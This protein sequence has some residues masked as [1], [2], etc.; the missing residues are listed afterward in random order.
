M[1][2][3]DVML[4]RAMTP[5][6]Q[7]ETYVSIANA[8]AAKAEKA[9]QDAEEAIATIE[10][11]ADE[12]A[13]AQ[14]SASDLLSTAQ[15][16]LETAQQA[17]LNIPDTEDIDAEV[18]KLVV[19]TNVI[20][21]QNAKTIQIVSTYPDNTLNTQNVTKLYKTTGT[22]EDGTMT[23]KAI[24]TYVEDVQSTLQNNINNITIVNNGSGEG[25]VSNLG[26]DNSGKLVIIGSDGNIIAGNVIESD[27]IEALILTGNY[28]AQEAVGLEVDYTN[29]YMKRVQQAANLSMGEDFDEY[30]MY[31]GRRRCV[32]DNDGLIIAFEGDNNFASAISGANGQVMV[33]Q[34]KFY[35]QRIPLATSLNT[36]GKIINKDSIMISTTSQNGFKL[37]P[38][39][40]NAAGEELDY[41]LFSAYEGGLYDVS[42]QTVP[43]NVASNVDF[44]HDLLTSVPNS[45]P[46]TGSSSLNLERAEQLA[47]NR[48]SGWH[49]MNMMAES[50]N[51]MLEIIEFGTMN[52]QVALGKG[53]CDISNSGNINYSA[54]TGSTSSLGNTSGSASSTTF[55]TN[56]SITTETTAGKVAISYRGMENPWGNTWNMLNGIFIVGNSYQ[57]GG[58]PK[59]CTNYSYNY[60]APSNDYQNAD[61]SLP[62]G[63]GWIATMGYG[64]KDLDWLLMPASCGNNANSSLP[65]GD[66][67]WFNNNLNGNRVVVSGGSWAFG[68]AN[69]PFYYGCDK[70]PSDTSYKSY[71]ARLMFIPEKNETYLANIAKA[72]G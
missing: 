63:E 12:I 42:A 25:G 31:G 13:I 40:R 8:A 26:A 24:K 61:F 17:Q 45:K 67:G 32:V 54:L 9:K 20:D 22:N 10:A 7:T 69:G 1:D 64:N 38:I 23:Q 18:K 60:S 57:D 68:E 19:N 15:E 28:T 5:Q 33:Y 3:I 53:I 27:L 46:I 2:I 43:T 62:S 66:N 44:N 52:G 30:Q 4:A 21:G 70:L 41:V 47:N 11:A 16:T 36:V 56:G 55:E 6:G 65:V 35:Y 71:G 58:I 50:A 72:Q 49:I 48:G 14:E 59:V 29:K 37:H 34:P 51:Q 39:F